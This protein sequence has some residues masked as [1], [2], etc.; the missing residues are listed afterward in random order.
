MV[1]FGKLACEIAEGHDIRFG[2]EARN[3]EQLKRVI[4]EVND[5]RFGICLDL[6]HAVMGGHTPREWIEHFGDSIAEIHVNGVYHDVN[7]MVEHQPLDRNNAIDYDDTLAALYACGYA[8]P[9][10]CE[11]QGLDIA[12]TLLICLDARERLNA[13]WN[14]LVPPVPD[15]ADEEAMGE[16]TPDEEDVIPPGEPE[17]LAPEQGRTA[18]DSDEQS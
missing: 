6:G 13:I 18:S 8:G 12:D 9:F 14:G 2:Y 3:F 1:R 15:V 5:P 16:N 7:G 11:L 17:V 4:K 10:Q